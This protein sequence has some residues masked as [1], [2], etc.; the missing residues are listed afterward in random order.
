MVEISDIGRDDWDWVI[1]ES[2]PLG[3]A[4]VVAGGF[5]HRLRDH[6][7]VI[8]RDGGQPVGF[9]VYRQRTSRWEIIGILSTAQREG[10]GSELL[11]EVERRA[12]QAGAEQVRI[13]TTNDNF[14][15]LRFLQLRGYCLRQ[16][17]PGA[18]LESKKLKGIPRDTPVIGLYGIEIRD[19]IILNK[20]LA[21]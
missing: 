20:N 12:K 19:E 16:L 6:P 10:V 21:G 14:P 3:G 11:Q 13:S 17:I 9:A 18:F 2:G 8:A 7:G 15:A 4:E 5:L 1:S